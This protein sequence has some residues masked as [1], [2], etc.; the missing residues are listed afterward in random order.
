M[1]KLKGLHSR[2]GLLFSFGATML[3]IG[4][5][6]LIGAGQAVDA[7]SS[8]TP[9]ILRAP[10]PEGIS[11]KVYGRVEQERI[12]SSR[13]L[14]AM[15]ATRLRNVEV[16]SDGTIDGAY[17]YQGIPLLHLLEII[18]T[19]NQPGDP[20]DRP[21][22]ML[23]V[24]ENNLGESRRF[25]YGELTMAGDDQPTMLAFHR[26]QL[27]PT[28]NPEEYKKN[29]WQGPHQGLRLV[30]PRDYHTGR[31]LDEV[32]TVKLVRPD[33][34]CPP[35]T[36]TMEK[37][38]KDA[39]I[40]NQVVIASGSRIIWR[41]R[42]SELGLVEKSVSDWRRIGHGQGLK[43][44]RPETVSG[45]QLETL[46]RRFVPDFKTTDLLLLVA[47]DGYR[48]LFSGWEII[49]HAAGAGLLLED[50][51]ETGKGWSLAASGDFFVDRCVWGLSHIVHIDGSE[52]DR[53]L[54]ESK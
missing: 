1:K 25:S 40:P 48:S 45:L 21:M 46:L 5:G 9:P 26:E 19:A 20:F 42:P 15:A 41:G 2:A 36:P 31:Y 50:R 38:G 44:V 32:K 3:V 11:L 14:G 49:E 53:F 35:D 12:F 47:V 18:L 8:A 33:W 54:Q 7:V 4:I 51:I 27:L 52:L 13:D 17:I 23:V 30:V 39:P 34:P 28:K 37:P 6:L 29:R 22:D 43:S 24:L 10:V 16:S